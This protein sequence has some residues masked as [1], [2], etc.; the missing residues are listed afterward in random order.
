MKALSHMRLQQAGT[1]AP[2]RRRKQ[3]QKSCS[4]LRRLLGRLFDVTP[5]LL[6]NHSPWKFAGN[7]LRAG[8]PTSANL[9][10][11]W[12]GLDQKSMKAGRTF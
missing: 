12:D 10:Q 3:K 11:V 7:F 1:H 6:E 2:P 8:W 4:P 5:T 9:G